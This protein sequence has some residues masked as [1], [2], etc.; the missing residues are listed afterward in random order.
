MTAMVSTATSFTGIFPLRRK[1]ALLRTRRAQL[2]LLACAV[3]ACTGREAG[4]HARSAGLLRDDFATEVGAGTA[5]APARIVSL[6]PAT[7]ELLFAIG[8]GSRLVGRTHWD[9]WP[10][11]AGLVPDLGPGLRPNIEAV[12]A[13]RPD[14]VV[15]YASEENRAAAAQLRAAGVAVIALKIDSIAQFLRATMILGAATGMTDRARHVA[16]T[17]SA[18]LSRVRARTASLPRRRVFWHV[19]DEPIITIGSGSYLNEL[20]E[21]AGAR[22]VYA[23]L[24]AP[25]PQVALEDVALR[26]PEFVLAGPEGARRLASEPGWQAVRAVRHGRILV[27]D[28]VL[29][30]RPSVRLGEA[31]RA[32]ANL[33]HPGSQN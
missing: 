30:G 1:G 14:L 31:A 12:L 10:D 20:V 17:V 27:V 16:D 24:S 8:A 28:T 3:A 11:S 15:I 2:F 26:D 7:T 4:H 5:A 21:I 9:N 23:D 22:N 32:L 18:S 25:S 33:L 6:N 29:V 19:W 13:Q